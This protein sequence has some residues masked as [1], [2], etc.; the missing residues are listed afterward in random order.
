MLQFYYNFSKVVFDMMI[1]GEKM[2]VSEAQ[3]RANLKMAKEK[4][5]EIRFR[6]PKG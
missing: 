2:S 5:D 4:T 6:D 3:K 1:G